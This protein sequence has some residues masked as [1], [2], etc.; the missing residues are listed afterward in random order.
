[1]P[2][3]PM[4]SRRP[5]KTDLLRRPTKPDLCH[6]FSFLILSSPSSFSCPVHHTM[7]LSSPSSSSPRPQLLQGFPTGPRED[8]SR[9]RICRRSRGRPLHHLDQLYPYSCPYADT[10]AGAGTDSAWPLHHPDQLYPYQCTTCRRGSS[11]PLLPPLPLPLPY[12]PPQRSDTT[13]S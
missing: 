1:M 8:L 3:S 2:P 10:G 4:T 11:G 12:L 5:G 7:V 6:S 13:H 9:P